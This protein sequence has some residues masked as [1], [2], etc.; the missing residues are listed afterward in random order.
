[1]SNSIGYN[2]RLDITTIFKEGK[3]EPVDLFYSSP[4]KLTNYFRLDNG[5]IEYMLMSASAGVMAKD[6]YQI[7]INLEANSKLVLS[8]QSFEKIHKMENNQSAKRENTINIASNAYLKFIPLPMIP[9]ADSAFNN[10]TQIKLADASS[11]LIYLDV[12]S[13][14]RY[15]RDER[16]KYRYYKSLVNVYLMGKLVF[17]DL[18]VFEPSVDNMECFGLFEGYSHLSNLLLFGFI[19]S[20]ET[21]NK[22]DELITQL[23]IDAGITAVLGGGYL[24]RAYANG[25]EP[26]MLFNSQIITIFDNLVR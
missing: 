3:T 13:C 12:L 14:G 22:I 23:Q 26:L 11:Q 6:N 9:F 16:F 25:S 1:M 10:I 20:E 18:C 17:R 21:K 8:A 19:L 5:G 2:A 4:Y 15:L 24:V 7:G